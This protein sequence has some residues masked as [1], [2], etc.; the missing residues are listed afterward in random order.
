MQFHKFI[1]FSAAMGIGAI[2]IGYLLAPQWMYS[3]YGIGIESVNEAN[4]VR[5]AYGGLFVASALL[6]VLGATHEGLH[7]PSL[8]YLLVFMLGF[9]CGRTISV[10]VDGVPSGLVLL[11]LGLEIV[12]S[13]LASI[14]LYTRRN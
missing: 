10:V 14:A 1:L 5:A 12:Y 3:F 13:T 2:G 11:L 6:F 9:A 7:I 8:I 4:M